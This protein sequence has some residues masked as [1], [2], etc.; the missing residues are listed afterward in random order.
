MACPRRLPVRPIA[1]KA[2]TL[3]ARRA[4]SSRASRSRR[5]LSSVL[6]QPRDLMDCRSER[7]AVCHR[8]LSQPVAALTGSGWRRTLSVVSLIALSKIAASDQM[9]TGR[10]WCRIPYLP[11]AGFRT[12]A[13]LL[14]RS[15]RLA[16]Q[17]RSSR[18]WWELARHRPHVRAAWWASATRGRASPS[19]RM[20]RRSRYAVLPW[21]V[22]IAA[23]DQ[24]AAPCSQVRATCVGI[25]HPR[26]GPPGGTSRQTRR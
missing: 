4:G 19:R 26:P 9:A 20:R 18:G 7:A 25:Q 10:R 2:L 16:I 5:I 14:R 1:G 24:R 21:P 11:C 13:T 12:R 3:A 22:A 6:R 23:R 8:I 15:P 17:P